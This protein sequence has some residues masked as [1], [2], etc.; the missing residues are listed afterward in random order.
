MNARRL[1]ISATLSH[2][3]A[4][5]IGQ[6]AVDLIMSVVDWRIGSQGE[7]DEYDPILFLAAGGKNSE[8]L[9]A[10]AVARAA[11]E[12]EELRQVIMA[13][14]LQTSD[15]KTGNRL[16]VCLQEII[17]IGGASW[18]TSLLTA[19]PIPDTPAGIGRTCGLLKTLAASDAEVRY[20]LA[21]WFVSCV[22]VKSPATVDS[23]LRLVRDDDIRLQAALPH[24]DML[25]EREQ[26][27]VVANLAK[28]MDPAQWQS[29]N[30]VLARLKGSSVVL[31]ARLAGKAGITNGEARRVLLNLVEEESNLASLQ[32]L[33]QLLVAAETRQ[34]WLT[35]D[36][37][38]RFART[39][40]LPV[41]VGA[42]NVLVRLV[43]N[44]PGR[45][46]TAIASW[47]EAAHEERVV[48]G[49]NLEELSALLEMSHAYLRDGAGVAPDAVAAIG[50]LVDDVV[51]EIPRDARWG[52]P[53]LALIKTIAVH[54]DEQLRRRAT[55]W[56]LGALD[57]IN[58][59]GT[60]D[61]AAFAQETL[62]RLVEHEYVGL[63]E[64]VSRARGWATENLVVVVNVIP[65]HDPLGARSQL[66]DEILRWD[67]DSQVHQA[68]WKIRLRAPGG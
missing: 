19:L 13:E 11:H 7:G 46:G 67:I 36:Q 14:F 10:A 48:R 5:H 44:E 51:N 6:D 41:R 17:T 9:R 68:I 54:P 60:G 23:Y 43:R 39:A 32:A 16:L 28:E 30:Q 59:A 58:V 65:T 12:Q 64:L 66:L 62:G 26:E 27:R 20:Q 34:E 31:Q 61:G 4:N 38:L 37:L 25:S 45:S 63:A 2:K 3:R 56:V 29:M 1:A 22:T 18:L 52:R 47:L 21:D 50:R 15:G 40:R 8:Q 55:G 24:L 49:A 33:Y 42:L 35:P 53:L 57:K